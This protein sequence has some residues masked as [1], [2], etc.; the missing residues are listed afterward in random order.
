MDS[1]APAPCTSGQ[2]YTLASGSHT[3]S[4]RA[5]GPLGTRGHPSQVTWPVDAMAATVTIDGAPVNL[6]YTVS[7][8][9]SFT[10]TATPS[11]LVGLECKVDAGAYETC[12]SPQSLSSLGEGPHTF[13]VKA[14]RAGTVTTSS[15][16]W[17]VD[18]TPPGSPTFTGTPASSALVNTTAASFSFSAV[19]ANTLA[20]ECSQDGGAF[21]TCTSPQMYNVTG[22][23]PHSF[24]A[25]AKDPAEN[26]VL[27]GTRSWTVDATAPATTL[28]QNIITATNQ[29]SVTFAYASNEANSTFSCSLNGVVRSCTGTTHQV[30][31][32]AVGTTY[33]FSITAIDHAGNPDPTPATHTFAVTTSALLRYAFESNVNNTGAASN[34]P[35]NYTGTSSNVTYPGGKFGGG[36]AF[37]SSTSSL[38]TLPVSPLI[39]TGRAYTVSIWW[40][41]ATVLNASGGNFPTLISFPGTNRLESYHGVTGNDLTN[42]VTSIACNSFSY[43]VGGWN[44]LIYRYPGSG[45][46]VELYVNGSLRFTLSGPPGDLFAALDDPAVGQNTN[47]GV[48]EVR[49]YDQVYDTAT[50]C[51]QI[52]GGTWTGSSCSLP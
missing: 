6:A 13:S 51:T 29:T 18:S 33:T 52:I 48:D 50:Q 22:D 36:I 23:G 27:L 7:K 1:G 37:G 38:V 28:S 21:A 32:L 44:N 30:T 26:T 11:D 19:D 9:A 8:S 16:T 15:R 14:T 43:T 3:I 5:V 25:R 35:I 45:S 24:T 31:G 39:H 34:T 10:F 2:M 46:A 20:Y 40:R 4:V 17:T 12:T 47:M 49:F 42:C 41:E